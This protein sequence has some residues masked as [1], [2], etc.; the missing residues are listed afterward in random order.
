VLVPFDNDEKP[1][2]L[3]DEVAVSG[4]M[5]DFPTR[6]RLGEDGPEPVLFR[7]L[8]IGSEAVRCPP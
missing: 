1:L 3:E 4:R 6:R 8:P 2:V 7:V 5:V